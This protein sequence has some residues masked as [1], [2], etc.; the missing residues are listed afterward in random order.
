MKGKI[1]ETEYGKSVRGED[2]KF[3][4]IGKTSPF[5]S[6][7]AGA[8]IEF[9]ESASIY[10]GKE[11]LWANPIAEKGKIL[12]GTLPA[13]QGEV[14]QSTVEHRK[15]P[16]KHNPAPQDRH[17]ELMVSGFNLVVA[18]LN[19]L[20]QAIERINEK[21]DALAKKPAVGPIKPAPRQNSDTL[22]FY[23]FADN[24]PKV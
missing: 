18:S 22:A 15:Q 9:Q 21:V 4:K 2:G 14:N 16:A 7:Q 6:L 24:T 12:G 13:P 8:E 3:Y 19:E 5:L 20:L 10:N 17:S 23:N 1:L 11:Y